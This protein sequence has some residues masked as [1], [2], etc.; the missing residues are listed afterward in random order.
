MAENIDVERTNAALR[1]LQDN[2]DRVNRGSLASFD[3]SLRDFGYRASA[4]GQT[5][6]SQMTN[7][8]VGF[9][10][11]I[12]VL[13][14]TLGQTSQSMKLYSGAL[15]VLTQQT[16]AL[17]TSFTQL[18][19]IGA[20]GAKGLSG[21]NENFQK[22]GMTLEGYSRT[23]AANAGALGR[24]AGTVG[25]GADAFADITGQVVAADKE[26]DK[27][28]LIGY[29]ADSMGEATAAYVGRMAQL[30]LTQNKTNADLAKGARDYMFQLDELSRVTG[31]SRKQIE[32]Q[33][34]ASRNE[35]QFR[36]T[37]DDLVAQGKVKEAQ[38][39]E[40]LSTTL[41]QFK[42]P[43]LAKGV[44]DLASG[45]T[46]SVE[47]Q[48]VFKSSGSRAAEIMDR[49]TNGQIDALTAQNELRDAMKDNIGVQRSY[50]KAVGDGESQFISY[51]TLSDFTKQQ[52]IKQ[53]DVEAERNKAIA[54]KG[55]EGYN[56]LNSQ[57]A[58]STKEFE[59][60]N[61]AM[62]AFGARALP[63]VVDQSLKIAQ[64]QANAVR[65]VGGVA[66]PTPI[67]G[68]I[69]TA[70][71]GA[72]GAAPAPS[73]AAGAGP[74]AAGGDLN[75]RV[76]KLNTGSSAGG[77]TNERL[78]ALA[79]AIQ[80]EYP[81]ARFTAFNDVFHQ[82]ERPNSAH[83]KNR[84]VDFSFSDR[85]KYPT[86]PEFAATVVQ[87]AK[88]LGFSNV[89]DEYS[90][91]RGGT[92]PHFHAEI[93]ARNGFS[94]LLSG[95]QSGYRPNIVMH[96]DE[97]L[98]IQPKSDSYSSIADMLKDMGSSSSRDTLDK[99]DELVNIMRNSVSVQQKILQAN[100]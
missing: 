21:L 20:L 61:R 100:Y 75:Q 26:F 99:L 98:S 38:Q 25:K 19:Q 27:L 66:G 95:P 60:L 53:A 18:S 51:A 5:I 42:D 3:R 92:G 43:A 4:A 39:L 77:T 96:G 14:A 90:Q 65:A 15:G 74:A 69:Y 89:I 91:N 71:G 6:T 70:P 30:G 31:M 36:A 17:T 88:S 34:A 12:R 1:E 86:T 28:R 29:N 40:A 24:F 9:G 47:A 44:R 81:D 48:K 11:Q 76:A 72:T 16:D 10:T 57:V 62:Q 87:F 32:D 46:T 84:A 33:Q 23:V 54:A 68:G 8:A 73:A 45:N 82:R 41:S 58:Q 64:T 78:V 2:L 37:L 63:L 13:Q 7:S 97:R 22:S 67:Q 85:E 94:G 93:S 83:T 56:A 50:A 35:S 59:R 52:E 79:E 80:R 49:L 55:Q